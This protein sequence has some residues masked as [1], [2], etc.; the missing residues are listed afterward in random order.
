MSEYG[1]HFDLLTERWIPCL[2]DMGDVEEVG[3][4]DAFRRAHELRGIADASPL[5]TCSLYRFLE[6]VLNQSLDLPD[7][8]AWAEHWEE[9]FVAAELIARIEE[10]CTGRFDL[11][12]ESHPF[13]QSADIPE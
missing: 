7:E 6:A 4:L 2:N 9:K 5:V 3:V 8:D 11:F 1:A 13:Y 12:D 10:A